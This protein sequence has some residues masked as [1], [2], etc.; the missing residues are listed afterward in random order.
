MVTT[1]SISPRVFT[2]Y[3]RDYKFQ[4]HMVSSLYIAGCGF[5][6]CFPRG[7]PLFGNNSFGDPTAGGTAQGVLLLS[8]LS[9]LSLSL[10]P[11][12]PISLSVTFCKANV[13]HLRAGGRT[14]LRPRGTCR[15]MLC[16]RQSESEIR[17]FRLLVLWAVQ[18]KK[19][20]ITHTQG[21]AKYYGFLFCVEHISKMLS[22]SKGPLP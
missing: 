1:V 2:L 19:W 4:I 22:G 5:V 11:F 7:L 13:D 12:P 17:A 20:I 18:Y 10:F 6:I 3:C 16:H 21:I 14:L 8:L 15:H 9:Y